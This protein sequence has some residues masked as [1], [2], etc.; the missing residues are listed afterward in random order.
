MNVAHYAH[1]ASMGLIIT[2]DTQPSEDGQGY[3]LT[4]GVYTNV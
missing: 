3:L 2:E 1:R 4:P